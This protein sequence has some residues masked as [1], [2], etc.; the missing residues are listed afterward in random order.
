[1]GYSLPNYF[2]DYVKEVKEYTN[3]ELIAFSGAVNKETLYM[4][5]SAGI[6]G[7]WCGLET[8]NKG[9]FKQVRPGDNL[10]ARIETLRNAKELGLKAWSSFIVGVGET[11]NDIMRQIEL[12]NELEVDNVGIQPFMPMPYTGMEKCDAPNP[13]WFAKVIAVTRISLDNPDIATFSS[14][15]HVNWGIR[16]G[17]NAFWAVWT[18]EEMNSISNQRR[19]IY[20]NG[21]ASKAQESEK[22]H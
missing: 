13:Y 20:T 9:V 2:Y 16:A 14:F 12:L 19:G 21:R 22:N 10:D 4:L 11:E 8:L 5:K 7:Y 3:L 15:P 17:A 6:D 1:M 18:K